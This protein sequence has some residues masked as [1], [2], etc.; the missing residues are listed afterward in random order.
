MEA[1]AINQ[2]AAR[3]ELPFLS[4]KD[5]INNERHTQTNLIADAIGFDSDIPIQEAGRRSALVLAN[6]MRRMPEP[7]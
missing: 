5:I 3:Y 4:V 2:I 6:V 7:Y 1:A